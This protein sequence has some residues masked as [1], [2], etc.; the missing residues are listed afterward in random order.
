M[1][2]HV[3]TAGCPSLQQRAQLAYVAM[4]AREHVDLQGFVLLQGVPL[5]GIRALAFWPVVGSR[6][7]PHMLLGE[8][9]GGPQGLV[10]T[11]GPT[12]GNLS[13]S[14]GTVPR[15]T[16]PVAPCMEQHLQQLE[17]VGSASTRHRVPAPV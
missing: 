17:H 4:G 14:P 12:E 9:N 10:P 7:A 13:P 1:S 8:D 3:D 15:E 5:L 16:V 2:R 6:A 11:S